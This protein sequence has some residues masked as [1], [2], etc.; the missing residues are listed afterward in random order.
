M[1][2]TSNSSSYSFSAGMHVFTTRA[3]M[4]C[5]GAHNN[6]CGATCCKE[7]FVIDILDPRDNDAVVSQLVRTYA[8]GGCSA[9]CRC[10]NGFSQYLVEFPEG[11]T[12]NQRILLLASFISTDLEFFDNNQ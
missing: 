1:L 6:C 9:F 2:T 11:A 4:C 10:Y 3:N 7:R 5:C 8:P 12:Q